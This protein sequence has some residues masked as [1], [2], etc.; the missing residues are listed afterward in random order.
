MAR[1]GDSRPFGLF[2]STLTDIAIGAIAAT[3]RHVTCAA[4]VRNITLQVGY[5]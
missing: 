4:I 2:A 1:D 5:V 3:P